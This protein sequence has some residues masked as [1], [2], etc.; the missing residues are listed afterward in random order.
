MKFQTTKMELAENVIYF[1]IH[2][3]ALNSSVSDNSIIYPYLYNVIH[4][5]NV[6]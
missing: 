5:H 3:H 4:T 2:I 1:Y 6:M